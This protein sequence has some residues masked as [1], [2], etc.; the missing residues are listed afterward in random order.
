MLGFSAVAQYAI[1]QIKVAPVVVATVTYFK[2]TQE[3]IP[4]LTRKP[5][6]QGY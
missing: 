5:E 1:A 2:M 3:P 6:M 4:F